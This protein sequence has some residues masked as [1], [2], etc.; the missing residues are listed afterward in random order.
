MPARNYIELIEK[1]FAV[2]DVLAQHQEG[3]ALKQIAAQTGLVKSSVF[4]ILHTL[5]ELGYVEQMGP[6]GAYQSTLKILALSRAAVTRD[7]L[8]RMARPHL[9]KL[10]D[11]LGES[12]WLGEKLRDCI[13][14]VDAVEAPRRLRL[15][16]DIG[17]SCP[18]HATAIGKVIAAY[19]PAEELEERLGAGALPAYTEKTIRDRDRLKKHLAQ[20]RRQGY[21]INNEETM[22]SAWL[23]GAPV[24]DASHRVCAALS[25]GAL[26]SRSKGD[27]RTAMI[28]AV[29]SQADAMSKRLAQVGYRSPR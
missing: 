4:R 23:V 20:I 7:L 3:C 19:L 10:R 18:M 27:W 5:K 15:S 11:D 12:A 9:H 6:E 14:L 26:V 22:E 21:A 25:M 29:V 8:I 16:L 24:F 28:E 1:T 13:L 17:D 2:L